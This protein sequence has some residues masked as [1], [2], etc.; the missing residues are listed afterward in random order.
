[1]GTLTATAEAFVPGGTRLDPGADS[2]RLFAEALAAL[3][4]RAP[5]LASSMQPRAWIGMGNWRA[6]RP[7][8]AGAL[9]P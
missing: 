9:P 7:D 1:M 5:P 3:V 6:F 4:R 8:G 2:P